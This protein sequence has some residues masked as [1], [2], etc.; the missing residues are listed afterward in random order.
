METLKYSVIKTE[1]QY[2][3]YCKKLEELLD[4]GSRSKAVQDEIELLTLLIEKYDEQH[5]TL[6]ETID[7]I[8]LLTHLMQENNMKSVDLAQL[9]GVSKGLVSDIL[10][11]KKGL[12]KEIIR[13]LAEHFKLNQESLNRPYQ[14]HSPRTS[15]YSRRKRFV[16]T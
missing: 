9:L 12:S 11:Y 6:D 15:R 7:P 4:S 14:L 1:T 16:R 8:E 10:S 13:K 3:K 5:N 2:N